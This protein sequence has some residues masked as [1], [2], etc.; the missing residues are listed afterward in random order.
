MLFL[1]VSLYD[2]LKSRMCATFTQWQFIKFWD[3]VIYYPKV[4]I[5]KKLIYERS[6]NIR[7]VKDEY[8]TKIFNLT[9]SNKVFK[10]KR[11]RRIH[12]FQF[13]PS[14]S[15][16]HP[17][18]I[19]NYIFPRTNYVVITLQQNTEFENGQFRC[20][21]LGKTFFPWALIFCTL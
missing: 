4:F 3:R 2:E 18:K 19:N 20:A 10:R 21:F 12:F 6:K 8:S 11:S 5:K 15:P 9:N 13:W 14:E 16:C 7:W 17:F 1:I